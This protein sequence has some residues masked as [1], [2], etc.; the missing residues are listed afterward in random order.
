MVIHCTCTCNFFRI[1]NVCFFGRD[2]II[3]EE[4]MG[5]RFLVCVCESRPFRFSGKMNRGKSPF[6]PVS[7]VSRGE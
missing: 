4:K 7:P 1:L 6:A 5:P 2:I 3:E